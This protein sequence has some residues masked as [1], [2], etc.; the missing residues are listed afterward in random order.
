MLAVE[1]QQHHT[2]LAQTGNRDRAS[3]HER[4]ALSLRR[5]L[6][7][8]NQGIFLGI[9]SESSGPLS[10][11]PFRFFEDRLDA[12]GPLA[13]A[14]HGTFGAPSGHETERVHDDGLPGARLAAEKV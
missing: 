14:H 6:S 11:L 5:D 2:H 7:A 13:R 9:G 4:P 3:R 12:G 1:F 8:E 10:D